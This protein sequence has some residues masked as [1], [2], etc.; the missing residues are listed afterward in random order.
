M[1]LYISLNSLK[2]SESPS[3]VYKV[4]HVLTFS[5]FSEA[6]SEIGNGSWNQQANWSQPKHQNQYN[7][8][9]PRQLPAGAH[10]PPCTG[11]LLVIKLLLV[12]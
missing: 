8:P 12:H 7:S 10:I 3:D 9:L 4:L 5:I 1:T 2:Y 11:E 6:S